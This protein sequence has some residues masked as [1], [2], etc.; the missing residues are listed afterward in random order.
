MV[1]GSKAVGNVLGGSIGN[2]IFVGTSSKIEGDTIFTGG[3]GD[4]MVLSTDRIAS[5]R[6]ELFAGNSTSDR[7][8]PLPGSSQTAI[9]GSVV[10]ID[11]VPQ[12]GW[13]GQATGQRGGAVSNVFTN[14]GFGTG[15]SQDVT[16]IH[17][18]DVGATNDPGDSIDF[19]LS[20]YSN[21]LRDMTSSDGGPRLGNAILSNT[22]SLGGTITVGNANVIVMD[23]SQT[24]SSAA[25]LSAQLASSATAIRFA[26][27]QTNQFNHYLIAYQDTGGYTRIAD[28]NIHSDS[29]FSATNQGDTLALSDL[30]RIG[31]V[32]VADLTASNIQFVL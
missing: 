10:S 31:S 27:A 28:M 18:F 23:S 24:F 12:L 2:D 19:S 32:Q 21:L 17:N 5:T 20:A 11:D 6:I 29:A 26:S 15:T 3:G 25:D 4:M 14:L 1:V 22:V 8:Q 30:V 16:T 13:W 7:V 9:F